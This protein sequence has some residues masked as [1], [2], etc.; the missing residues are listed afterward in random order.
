M[1]AVI[2]G[3]LYWW[4]SGGSDLADKGLDMYAEQQG[5]G[6]GEEGEY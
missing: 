3:F 1:I 4:T 6:Q 2:A 5:Y